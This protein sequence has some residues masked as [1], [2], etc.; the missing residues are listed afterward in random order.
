MNHPTTPDSGD[1]TA[2]PFPV[3]M[4]TASVRDTYRNA[5]GLEALYGALVDDRL[6]DDERPIT[7]S[8][9]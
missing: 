5:T 2:V 8:A 4:R 9:T 1:E 7:G 3:R 6:G